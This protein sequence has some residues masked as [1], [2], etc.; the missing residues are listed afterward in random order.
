MAGDE[1]EDDQDGDTD[2]VGTKT[3]SVD[4]VGKFEGYRVGITDDEDPVG[5]I[6]VLDILI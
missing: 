5:E 3:P 6:V 2:E 4:P 1:V